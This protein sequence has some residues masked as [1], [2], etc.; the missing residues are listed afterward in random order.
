[1]DT[2]STALTAAETGHLVLATLHTT[3][4]CQTVDRI[5]DIFP[6]SQQMQVRLQLSQALQ[7]VISQALL[8]RIGGGRVAALEILI[9]NP[10][11]RSLIREGKTFQ[12]ASFMQ[13]GSKDGMQTLDGALADLVR[14]KLVTAEEAMSKSGNAEQLGNALRLPTC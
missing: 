13:L 12:L 10:A 14:R 1:M 9:A 2:V 11:V 4:A 8:R 6:P 5:V 7:V 3:D